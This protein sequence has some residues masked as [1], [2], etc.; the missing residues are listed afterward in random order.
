MGLTILELLYQ[1]PEAPPPPK[2]PPPNPPLLPILLKMSISN[3][4]PELD[5]LLPFL[6]P[7]FLK[8]KNKNTMT[9]K[10]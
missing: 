3:N 2:L 8:I 6:P 7:L 9:I 4:A 10:E 1:L 5:F